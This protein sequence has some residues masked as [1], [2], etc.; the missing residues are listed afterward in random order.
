MAATISKIQTIIGKEFPKIVVPYID[1]AKESI[2]ILVFD[3][4][5]YPDQPSSPVQL[6]NQAIVRAVRR[7]VKIKVISN[8]PKILDILSELG[9]K[10]KHLITTNLVHSKLMIIDNKIF[11]IGSHNYTQNAFSVNYEA[12]ILIEAETGLDNFINYFNNLFN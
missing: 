7:N 10:V 12:S 2:S 8:F 6:F 5:W 3:W 1:Q 9:C 11:V 4:R